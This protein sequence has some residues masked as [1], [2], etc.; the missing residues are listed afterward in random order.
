[1]SLRLKREDTRFAEFPTCVTENSAHAGSIIL[2]FILSLDLD[3]IYFLFHFY[4]ISIIIFFYLSMC[5]CEIVFHT[6][7]FYFLFSYI[8]T[9]YSFDPQIANANRGGSKFFFLFNF[10]S[11]LL[12]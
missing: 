1:M 12:T 2:D 11:S 6:S 4:F 8:F 7:H 9:K 3:F 10:F 5:L